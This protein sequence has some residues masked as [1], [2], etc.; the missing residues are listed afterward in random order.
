MRDYCKGAEQ[1]PRR[2]S[3]YKG[4]VR[5]TRAGECQGIQDKLTGI[6]LDFAVL[7]SKPCSR[8]TPYALFFGVE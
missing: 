4:A 7:E 6:T 2:G 5:M 1:S 3:V 8:G